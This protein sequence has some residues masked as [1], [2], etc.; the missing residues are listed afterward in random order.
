MV[1]DDNPA[2][3]DILLQ[4][5]TPYYRVKAAN[6]GQ[7]AIDIALSDDKPDLILLDVM[8]PDIDGYEVCKQLQQ[9]PRTQ[10]IPIIFVSALS[11]IEDETKGLA[12]G[13]E[14][15]IRK[16]VSPPI[17]LARIKTHLE[18]GKTRQEL[19]DTLQNTLHGSIRMIEDIIAF[20]NPHI[21]IRAMRLKK[22]I[23]KVAIALEL[24]KVWR[25]EI[26]AKISQLGCISID[27]AL[28]EKIINGEELSEQELI[29]YQKYPIY[30]AN[31][32]HN[33]PRFD[34]FADQIEPIIPRGNIQQLIHYKEKTIAECVLQSTIYFE[35]ALS[36]RR[37]H[38]D[39]IDDMLKIFPN[40]IA[41]KFDT[42]V[43]IGEDRIEEIPIN[44]L[45]SGL[46]LAENLVTDS[47]VIIIHKG[48]EMTPAM[49]ARLKENWLE[50]FSEDRMIKVI[51]KM[52]S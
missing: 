27:E 19:S 28:A 3:I 7:K 20:S 24:K 21:F 26:L 47:G 51:S 41:E 6:N 50:Q 35:E 36:Q 38:Q 39:I 12:C 17:V 9:S 30:S 5:L 18:L 23:N 13:A 8:M 44:H 25:Y 11:D 10:H 32:L 31:L 33:I 52:T 49:I 15:Y 16:P 34:N 1:V 22:I 42:L 46:D 29:D 43:F 4:I 40:E 45:C 37:P 48:T 14:D 2:N